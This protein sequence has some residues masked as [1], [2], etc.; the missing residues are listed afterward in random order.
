MKAPRDAP[1][2]SSRVKREYRKRIYD[3]M[4]RRSSE[5]IFAHQNPE[6]FLSIRSALEFLAGQSWSRSENRYQGIVGGEATER[7]YQSFVSGAVRLPLILVAGY[8]RSGT[9][10]MQTIVRAA[11][12]RNICEIETVEDRF[13][14]WEYPK[15]N[16]E[17]MA[18]IMRSASDCSWVLVSLRSFLDCAASLAVGRG[19]TEL[20]D[21]AHESQLWEAWLPLLSLPRAIPV[22]FHEISRLSPHEMAHAIARRTGVGIQS[23]IDV[24][25]THKDLM[26]QLRKGVV[27]DFRQSNV[28][29][30]SR[31]ELLSEARQWVLSQLG[32]REAERLQALY[33]QHVSEIAP[34]TSEGSP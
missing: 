18:R 34:L 12:S 32:Q 21:V 13:S 9:T 14:L 27:D 8:P 15:H 11:F 4:V 31:S 33:D 20:V 17:A 19:G 28:P 2:T 26:L 24:A 23:D 25:A 16:S 30:A 22:S 6:P 29:Q 1:L 10:S 5:R 7:E 3:P